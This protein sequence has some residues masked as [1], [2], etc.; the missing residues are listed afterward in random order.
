MKKRLVIFHPAIVPYRIDFFNSLYQA[1]DAS[2]YFMYDDAKEQSFH[3]EALKKRLDF[4][5]HYLS[6]GLFGRKNLRLQVFSLLRHEKPDLVFCSE[7]NMLGL[8]VLCYKLFCN[9]KL[10]VFTICD[11]SRDIAQKTKGLQKYLRAFLL[12]FYT[13]VILA[14]KDA[15]A[16][17]QEH[18]KKQEKFLY[19]PIIQEEEA[20]RKDLYE[21]L[22]ATKELM[23]EYALK[24]KIPI[25]FVGRLIDIKNLFVLIRAFAGIADTYPQTV[26]VLVG[27]GERASALKEEAEKHKIGNRIIF[28]GK[29]QGTALY[30][31]YNI[32]QLFVLPSYFERFGAV[33]NE[34]LIAGC[35]TLC[36]SLAGA[37][38]LIEEPENGMVFNPYSETEL[39]E[40]LQ[41]AIQ[42]SPVLENAR[43][44][45]NKMPYAYAAYWEQL[46]DRIIAL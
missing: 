23:E 1:Y 12:R 40:K 3:Q 6:P 9:R 11:D 7:F 21:A 18:F 31:W 20:F 32:G 46:I 41:Q 19:F 33:A 8:F 43:V 28:A 37:S 34:A 15:Q 36:S 27:E 5:P 30:A 13:G 16:W 10:K 38:G 42:K 2:F 17:Y 24:G 29:K 35:Y 44:K 45:A 4:T 14:S 26:L 22:P 39:K 25:L